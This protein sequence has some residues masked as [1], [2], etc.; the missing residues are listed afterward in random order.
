MR[1]SFCRGCTKFL[2]PL[3]PIRVLMHSSLSALSS[4]DLLATLYIVLIP[5]DAFW[6]TSSLGGF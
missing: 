2:F 1:R 6:I 4:P 5:Q 3:H